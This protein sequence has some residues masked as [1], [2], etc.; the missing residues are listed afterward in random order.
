MAYSQRDQ[1]LSL[2]PQ[3][4]A[5]AGDFSATMCPPEHKL[6]VNCL[7]FSHIPKM[8]AAIMQQAFSISY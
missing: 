7:I 6:K 2:R 3:N 8:L 1:I 5:L 4:S